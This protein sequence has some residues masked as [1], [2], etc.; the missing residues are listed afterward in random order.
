[1][2]AVIINS[3]DKERHKK[4][5]GVAIDALKSRGVKDFFVAGGYAG[6]G[7]TKVNE[8]EA[9]TD[10]LD[11]LKKA[12]ERHLENG[13]ILFIYMTGKGY[14][15]KKGD[16]NHQGLLLKNDEKVDY[17]N[18]TRG[19]GDNARTVIIADSP[20]FIIN[21][22]YE[23][24]ISTGAIE[25]ETNSSTFANA[26]WG[27]IK[28][29]KFGNTLEEIFEKSMKIYEADKDEKAQFNGIF[30]RSIPELYSLKTLEKDSVIIE[31]TA[32]WCHP[33]QEIKPLVQNMFEEYRHQIKFYTVDTDENL[34][35]DELETRFFGRGNLR[36]PTFLFLKNG[37]LI[38]RISGGAEKVTKEL[39]NAPERI[40]GAKPLTK[41]KE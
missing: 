31:F 23:V 10:G 20:Y 39:E 38:E 40:F 35:R 22:G 15:I 14:A 25:E 18:L 24:I 1:M 7:K 8:F 33:C 27:G 5:A 26:F 3:S 12:L 32:K 34:L 16:Y 30:A 19:L 28:T 37:G 4:N 41:N 11:K 21:Q 36:M 9:T 17:W 29:G 13:D 6:A 2:I